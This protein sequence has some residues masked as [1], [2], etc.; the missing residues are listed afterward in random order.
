[1]TANTDT[2]YSSITSYLIY[3]NNGGSTSFY[4][5]PIIVAPTSNSYNFTGLSSGTSYLFAILA[6][7]IFGNG[8]IS[9][10]L[11]VLTTG[12]PSQPQQPVIS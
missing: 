12:V 11:S 3:Y 10:N 7:N 8:P 5:N 4:S 9:Q 1:M 2:G 6:K